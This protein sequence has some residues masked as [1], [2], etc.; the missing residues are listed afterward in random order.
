MDPMG[1]PPPGLSPEPTP[2]TR[3]PMALPPPEMGLKPSAAGGDLPELDPFAP[4]YPAWLYRTDRD[5]GERVLTPPPEPDATQ[6][7]GWISSDA[8]LYGELLRRFEC[9]L[10]AYRRYTYGVG[11]SYDPDVDAAFVS[12]EVVIQVN[13]IA[14]MIAGAP[15]TVRYAWRT[16][17][18]REAAA[19]MEQFAR[20][21]VA[22]WGIQ[23]RT[24]STDLLWDLAWYALVYGRQC[25]QI[26]NDLEDGDF[27]WW[28]EVLDPATCFPV[29]GK[30][31]HGLLRMTRRFTASTGEVL[32][33]YDP[34]GKDRI[35]DRLLAKSATR[36]RTNDLDLTE[37]RTVE[38]VWTRWHRYT[39]VDTVRLELVA[40]ELGVV[41]F[42]YNLAPG[43]A[44]SAAAPGNLSG[45][46]L[47][48]TDIKRRG[49]GSESGSSRQ[50]DI[51]EKGQSFFAPIRDA[52]RQKEKLLGIS[53]IAAEQTINPATT[54]TFPQGM[55]PPA[56][57]DLTPGTRNT[58]FTGQ[59]TEPSIPSMRPFDAGTLLAE[60]NSE[61][62]KGML[63]DVIFGTM[64]GSNITGFASD[65]LMAAAKDRINPYMSLTATTL[66]DAVA[67]AAL[68]FRNFGHAAE[69]LADGV[70]IIPRANRGGGFV[71]G[72]KPAPAPAW[73][74]AIVQKMMSL[75]AQPQQQAPTPTP[76]PPRGVLPTTVP[77][78]GEAPPPNGMP[79]APAGQPAPGPGLPPGGATPPPG[80][81]MGMPGQGP[82]GSMIGMPGFVDPAWTLPSLPP[83]D[84]PEVRI[85]RE[86]IDMVA[87]R[88][89]ISLE[90]LGL[91]SRTALINYLTQAVQAKL[92]RRSTAMDQLPEIDDPLLE[93]QGI[94]AEDAFT[95]PDMLRLIHYPRALAQQGDVDGWLTYWA[96]ILLP[97]IL[98]AMQPVMGQGPPAGLSPQGQP[99]S[100]PRGQAPI[101][102]P[103]PNRGAVG[104]QNPAAMGQ[105]PGSRGQP[106]GRPGGYGD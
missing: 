78:V 36:T 86:T 106:V 3:Y 15:I 14:S 83:A 19:R 41:P 10:R 39:Q 22:Q 20:W 45:T 54:D 18:E 17:A 29:W 94:V 13:K 26:G 92:M 25:V 51:A 30:S 55:K 21:F 62:A 16:A 12:D 82:G 32:D 31:K 8:L 76:F 49:Y 9:D 38:Q 48:A 93:W 23:H 90:A 34:T 4:K 44:G 68:L 46:G 96:T 105:G 61:L 63:P 80:D 69:G 95:D 87:A 40:H 101:A 35:A 27:P 50:R 52:L 74:G 104:G 88:P 58:R 5:T 65:S 97:Q 91:S 73:A 72:M 42:L 67:L 33:E 89:E 79:P 60:L 64:E 71:N 99:P 85:D 7:Q 57:L 43:E 11:R 84:E 2:G 75:L 66:A 28:A 53:M 24:G 81:M 70:L 47:S 102:Q 98:T 56:G 6:F 77:N 103:G 37:D 1:M 100:G 59:Q